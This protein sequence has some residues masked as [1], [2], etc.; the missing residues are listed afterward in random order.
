[1]GKKGAAEDAESATETS[2]SPLET[3][4]K[5]E[6]KKSVSQAAKAGVIMPVSRI[7]KHLRDGKRSKRVGNGA[8]I[9]LAAVLEYVG[10]EIFEMAMATLGK[11]KRITVT[12][13]VRGI[14]SDKELNKLFA[15]E[16]I[17]AGDRVTNIAH[18]VTIKP[19]VDGA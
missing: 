2:G 7:N 1:M 9:Y 19:P 13:I 8:P 3:M 10:A 17:F 4:A 16:A 18:A 5:K 6:K 11:R 14:R 12:D 15:G